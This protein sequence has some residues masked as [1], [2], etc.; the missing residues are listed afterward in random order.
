VVLSLRRGSLFS[1]ACVVLVLLALASIRVAA[2]R[3]VVVATVRGCDYFVAETPAGFAVLEW[4]GGATPTRGNGI[5]GDFESYGFLDVYDLTANRR[6]HV[7]VEDFWLTKSR[8][9]AKLVEKC[10]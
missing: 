9:F 1:V 7:W 5:V 8:A 3:G 2:A 4:Y 6:I 10:D